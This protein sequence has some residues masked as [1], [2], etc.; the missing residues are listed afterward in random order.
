MEFSKN[1]LTEKM[2]RRERARIAG[3]QN[4]LAGLTMGQTVERPQ[5]PLPD[6]QL[7]LD[8]DLL[9]EPPEAA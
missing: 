7:T 4:V 1:I 3:V 6:A 9:P 5:D 8:F 2:S